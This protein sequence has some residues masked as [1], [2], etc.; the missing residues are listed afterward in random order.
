MQDHHKFI[1]IMCVCKVTIDREENHEVHILVRVTWD[2]ITTVHHRLRAETSSV[3]LPIFEL[4]QH[5]DQCAVPSK[6]FYF[7]PDIENM[8]LIEMVLLLHSERIF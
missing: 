4:I 5:L 3:L 7:C 2:L 6:S 1:T 8:L